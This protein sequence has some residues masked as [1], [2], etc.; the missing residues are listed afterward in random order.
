VSKI[1][2]RA[3]GVA[4][5]AIFDT[6]DDFLAVLSDDLSSSGRLVTLTD[7]I[8]VGGTPVEYNIDF[9]GVDGPS[10]VPARCSRL[11]LI[12]VGPYSYQNVET[13]FASA[14]VFGRDGGLPQALQL[15][16]RLPRSQARPHPQRQIARRSSWLEPRRTAR[17][18]D[19]RRTSHGRYRSSLFRRSLC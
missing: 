2:L 1:A 14:R 6:G 9:F 13:C 11:N 7:S 10:N 4:T 3:G 8:R 17:G 19:K 5:R 16:V 15:D 18:R 12:E